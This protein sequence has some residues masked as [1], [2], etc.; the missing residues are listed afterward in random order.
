M[1]LATLSLFFFVFA[2]M[3]LLPQTFFRKEGRRLTLGWMVTSLPW[4][5][6]PVLM[7]A[8]YRGW[9]T[10]L[11]ATGSVAAQELEA[12]AVILAACALALQVATTAVHRVPLALWHQKDDAPK[13]I[14]TYGPYQRVRHPF[15]VSFLLLMV[16]TVLAAPHAATIAD[17][18]VGF[19]VLSVTAARE[20][21]RL[22]G[23]E[24]GAEYAA[25]LK[26]TGRFV[27][28]VGAAEAA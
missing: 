3:W 25:Y 2:S 16:A 1:S 9:L 23:S 7:I 14:V 28:R 13:S 17:L 22:L 10:P 6:A 21:K 4:G 15:Y 24:F 11:V 12:V 26:R 8:A 19:V 27:P 18:V 5:I 20:E